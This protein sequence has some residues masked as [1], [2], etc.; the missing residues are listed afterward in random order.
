MA[1]RGR[2]RKPTAN[3]KLTGNY[4]GDRRHADEP[5]PDVRIPERPKFLTGEGKKE[6]ERIAPLLA[7]KKCLTDWDR[8][9]LT[10]YCKEWADYVYL[11]RKV[12]PKDYLVQ[13]INGNLIQ[14]PLIAVRNRALKNCK[15]IAAE[16]GL[17]PSSRT[18]LSIGDSQPDNP[19]AALLNRRKNKN[20]G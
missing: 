9:M 17:S 4:R 6:W 3:L 2:P 7:D 20:A 5:T 19:F 12:K 14:N 16:F 1:R 8:A 15:E 13:T 18:R 10:A 11:S